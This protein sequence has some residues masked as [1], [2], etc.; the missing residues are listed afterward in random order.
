MRCYLYCNMLI[1][2]LSKGCEFFRD[3]KENEYNADGLHFNWQQVIYQGLLCGFLL[4][5]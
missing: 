2:S 3:F 5:I 4:V 1:F